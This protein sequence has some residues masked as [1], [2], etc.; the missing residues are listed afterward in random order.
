MSDVE[1]NDRERMRYCLVIY[2]KRLRKA[3]KAVL[4][5]SRSVTRRVLTKQVLDVKL[6]DVL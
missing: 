1:G 3:K 2:L 5:F 4:L 6:N